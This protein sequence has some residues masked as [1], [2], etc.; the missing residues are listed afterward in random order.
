MKWRLERIGKGDENER[1][2][3]GR[4]Q[5]DRLNFFKERGGGMSG[6][7]SEIGIAAIRKTGVSGRLLR[8]ISPLVDAALG[9][10]NLRQLYERDGLRG[11]D[12]FAFVETFV[13]KEGIK[14]SIDEAELS[15]IPKQG[16]VIIV[17]NHPMGG[18][19]G[20]ILTWLLRLVRP[21]YKAFVNV[22][23]SFL[24]ELK[25]FFIFTNPM[26][27]GSTANYESIHLSRRW[28]SQ[29]HCLLIFPAGRVG[30]YR[31]EKGYVT[32]EP[33]DLIALSLG[34]MTKA[35]FVPVFVEGECSSLFSFLSWYIYPMKLLFLI[36][37]FL[38]SFKK[39][40]VFH[41]GRP[42]PA[43]SLAAMGK[44][45][46]NAWLRMRC[47]LQCPAGEGPIRRKR[48][49][50]AE[51]GRG[52]LHPE[53]EDYIGR[54]GLDEAELTELTEALDGDQGE[55]G[56]ALRRLAADRATGQPSKTR[57]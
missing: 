40:V 31:P 9:I 57:R 34:A 15:R 50:G 18:L 14:Y 28:L 49:R 54:Y 20:I 43:S 11:L 6:I 55:K 35:V 10:R 52:A 8:L 53:V 4:I 12:R 2:P 17:A 19:E 13:E 32:D 36:W 47:Y 51:P 1:V 5:A 56:A 23:D 26:A 24:E 3:D 21:D 45:R 16:P 7:S 25:E 42:I 44:R 41:V 39:T 22:M 48:R 29:G 27:K 37:E 38:R 30:L 46:A 33:W